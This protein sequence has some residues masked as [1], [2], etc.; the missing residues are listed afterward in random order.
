MVDTEPSS[1]STSSEAL[2]ISSAVPV[3]KP[4]KESVV[5]AVLLGAE[6]SSCPSSEE[7]ALLT[8]SAMLVAK[9]DKESAGAVVV[10]A[11]SSSSTLLSLPV[12]AGAEKD[13]CTAVTGDVLWTGSVAG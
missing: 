2:A 12:G 7:E 6:P 9:P 3:A 5:L 1:S 10:A 4:D 11:E 13:S 8:S